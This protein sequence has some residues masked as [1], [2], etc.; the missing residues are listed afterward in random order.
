MPELMQTQSPKPQ[1]GK[2]MQGREETRGNSINCLRHISSPAKAV[3]SRLQVIITRARPGTHRL[4]HPRLA[5]GRLLYICG[6][7]TQLSG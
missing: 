5:H 2:K 6:G 3:K 1:E 4:R 7:F